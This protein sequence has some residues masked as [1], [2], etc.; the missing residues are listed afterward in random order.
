[1]PSR[2]K[3][4]NVTA[5]ALAFAMAP[6]AAHAENRKVVVQLAWLPNAAFAGEIVALA[7]GYFAERGL[8][9]EFL[10]GGPG[11]N[12]VQELL[13]GTSDISITYAPMVMYSVNRGLPLA[14]FAAAF[15]KAPLTFYSLKDKGITSVADWDGMRVGGSQDAI[16]Q[17]KAILNH[18]GLNFEDITFVQAQVP[19]LLQDQVDIVGSWPTNFAQNRPIIEHPNGYNAQSIWDNGLQFQSNYY[20][21]RTETLDNDSDMLVAFLEAVDQGWAFS[22][23]NPEQAIARVKAFAPALD[24]DS[25]IEALKL[26]TTQYVYTDETAEHGFG[27]ISAER[28]QQTLD[29]YAGLGEISADLTAADVLDASILDAAERTRR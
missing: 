3:L 23:D 22:A 13:S 27:N 21:A 20:I 19:G 26:I 9:V 14:T 17:V 25:E 5:A 6:L 18:N 11:A 12:T 7:N 29:T 2:R 28:W 4:L 10:P 15:Q 24:T 1:M 16:P 8:D